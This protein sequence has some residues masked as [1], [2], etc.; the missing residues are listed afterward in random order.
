MVVMARIQQTSDDIT[1][2]KQKQRK[3]NQKTNKQTHKQS[4]ETKNKRA[5]RIM[6][7]L[8]AL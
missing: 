1:K 3:Q 7:N 5:T 2:A 4:K 6:Q 8:C